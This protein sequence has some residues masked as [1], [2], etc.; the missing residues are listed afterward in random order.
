MRSDGLGAA[1]SSRDGDGGE[2]APRSGDEE[3]ADRESSESVSDR[4][5]VSGAA[6]ASN[7]EDGREAAG[8]DGRQGRSGEAAGAGESN[9]AEMQGDPD[10]DGPASLPFETLDLLAFL[11]VLGLLVAILVGARRA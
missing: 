9:A 11:T 1:A 7:S 4:D 5:P 10:S 8:S 3:G 2:D 6:S